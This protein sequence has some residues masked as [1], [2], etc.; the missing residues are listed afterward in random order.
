MFLTA[1]MSN[2]CSTRLEITYTQLLTHSLKTK[3][4]SWLVWNYW[5]FIKTLCWLMHPHA[6]NPVCVGLARLRT[7]PP[8][9]ISDCVWLSAAVRL[10]GFS[11]FQIN[12]AAFI[13][14]LVKHVC[15]G[16]ALLTSDPEFCARE[17]LFRKWKNSVVASPACSMFQEMWPKTCSSGNLHFCDVTAGTDTTPQVSD[18]S[19]DKGFVPLGG[20]LVSFPLPNMF[21]SLTRQ[22]SW[23]F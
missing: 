19:Q 12:N 14:P 16:A 18:N 15:A 22:Q 9:K 13:K 23:H 6:E 21:Y 10:Q 4:A 1:L 17:L 8:G 2:V 11:S 20:H 5:R 3:M 7:P